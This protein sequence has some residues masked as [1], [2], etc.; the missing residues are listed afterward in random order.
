MTAARVRFL[1]LLFVIMVTLTGVLMPG[2]ITRGIDSGALPVLITFAVVI[3]A[4]EQFRLTMPGRLPTSVM[5]SAAGMAL[6]VTTRLPDREFWC[7]SSEVLITA[8]VGQAAGLGILVA[9]RRVS[10]NDIETAMDGATRLFSVALAGALAREVPLFRGRTLEAA[11]PHW[12]G[13]KLALVLLLIGS[14]SALFENPLRSVGRAGVERLT[15]WQFISDDTHTGL[16]ISAAVT[17]TGA[18]VALT[19]PVLGLMAIPLTLSFLGFTDRAV[20]RLTQVREIY[21]QSLRA[22]ANMPEVVGYVDRGHGER[23]SEV[24]SLVGREMRISERELDALVKAALLHDLGQMELRRILPHGATVRAAPSDQQR[25]AE[26]G[27]RLLDATGPSAALGGL[28]STQAIPYYRVLSG[29][30]DVPIGGRII[31]VANAFDDY[32]GRLGDDFTEERRS[33]ME[34]IYLGLGYEYDPRVV[35]ALTRVL[36]RIHP[37]AELDR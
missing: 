28:V 9:R 29:R 2:E 35:D 24:A 26:S 37:M 11:S 19:V 23:V 4:A 13:W 18:L 3:A 21:G 33:A 25:I 22:L 31:K 15:G 1:T 6:A 34:R 27:A 16:H 20:R 17:A 8:M 12:E 36:D 14:V 10:I 32:G 7:S 5:S 30:A